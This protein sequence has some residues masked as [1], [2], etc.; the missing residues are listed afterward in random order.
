MAEEDKHDAGDG[1]EV[2]RLVS[3]TLGKVGPAAKTEPLLA[4][5]VC[6]DDNGG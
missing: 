5:G 3:G 1:A 2:G 6:A 4:A